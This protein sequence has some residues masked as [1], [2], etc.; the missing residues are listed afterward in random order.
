MIL[1]DSWVTNKSVSLAL[2]GFRETTSINKS[3][4][5]LGHL[6]RRALFWD[7]IQA[8]LE[9]ELIFLNIGEWGESWS[10]VWPP[11]NIK[12]FVA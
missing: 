11:V 12:N 1:D 2:Q 4:L 7:P 3:L 5:A 9:H 8:P 6:D 10:D